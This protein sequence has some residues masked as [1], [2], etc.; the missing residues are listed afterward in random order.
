MTK[1]S[2]NQIDKYLKTNKVESISRFLGGE[3]GFEV[4]VKHS[5]S[6]DDMDAFVESVAD[7]LFVNGA[8]KPALR[9]SV[10]FKAILAYF[11]NIKTEGMNNDRLIGLYVTIRPEII[12]M[13][14]PSVYEWLIAAVDAKVKWTLDCVL[15]VQQRSLND[16][17]AEINAE[18]S[19]I[20]EQMDSLLTVFERMAK[21]AEGFNKEELMADIKKIANKNE[22]D[23]ARSILYQQS[24]GAE[25]NEP[26]ERA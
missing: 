25:R 19:M 13:I 8:Y 17:V 20:S 1:V 10:F 14:D 6:I 16:A 23:I 3:D 7:A 15:S 4:N 22:L 11:T 9:E 5:I 18:K 26:A 2:F 24:E 21:E 12:S